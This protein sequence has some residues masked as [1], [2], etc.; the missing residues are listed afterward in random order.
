MW[1]TKALYESD[2]EIWE[3][4]VTDGRAYFFDGYPNT[5]I[6]AVST[7]T[8]QL[9][10]TIVS[11]VAGY[12]VALAYGDGMV[13][14]RSLDRLF[15][16]DVT[17]T[18]AQGTALATIPTD[19][20]ELHVQ[21]GAVCWVSPAQGGVSC[22][23]TAGGN[24]SQLF[25]DQSQPADMVV[26]PTGLYW[27][28]RGNGQ[29]RKGNTVLATGLGELRSITLDGDYLYVSNKSQIWRMTKAGEEKRLLTDPGSL[30]PDDLVVDGSWLYWIVRGQTDQ[31]YRV[32]K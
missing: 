6:R 14:W 15:K 25:G 22:V 26:E 19:V 18:N 24:V 31:V 32:A 16:A 30:Q 17:K 28:N 1:S 9:I 12:P 13:Y 3:P 29:V 2:D 21:S 10:S 11:T 5:K 23:S 8:I 20:E 7:G 27:V 4:V